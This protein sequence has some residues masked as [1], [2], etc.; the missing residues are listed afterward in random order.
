MA[1]HVGKSKHFYEENYE[2]CSLL[3]RARGFG[4]RRVNAFMCLQVIYLT[5]FSVIS[6]RIIFF[7]VCLH[8]NRVGRVGGNSAFN[9][10]QQ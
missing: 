9:P 10:K 1:F 2:M 3:N 7:M 5:L 6:G 4:G 8:L